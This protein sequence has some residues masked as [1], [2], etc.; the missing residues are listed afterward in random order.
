MTPERWQMV[1]GILESAMELRPADRA[2]Y[3]DQQCSADPSL[4]QEVDKLLSFEGE[5]DPGFLESPVAPDV[6][7]A[8]LS[9]SVDGKL[10]LGT[11]LGH[12]EVQVLLGEGGMGEVYRGRDTRLNRTVA[13]KVIPR[14]LS[15]DPLRRQRFD[16]EARAISALQ[17]P[18]ICTLYDVGD[19]DETHFLVME[20]LEGETLATRLRRGNLPLEL[21][22]RYAAEV[23]DA[24][25]AAHRRGIVH[26][27]LKPANIFLTV[28]GES[29]VLD[30]GLAKLDETD[31]EIAASLE[32][33]VDL[34]MLST[35]GLAMGTVPYMSPEQAQGE[36]LDARA[37]IFSL[38]AVLYE[39][40]TGQMAFPGKTAAVPQHAIPDEAPS[41]PSLVPP[42]PEGL[43]QVV[44]KA[45]EKHRDQ[46][47]QSA[48][49]LRADLER[50]KRENESG[51][52]SAVGSGMPTTDQAAAA[53][54]RRSRKWAAVSIVLIMTLIISA[55]I[56]QL[57]R[58]WHRDMRLTDKDTV[59]LSDFDNLTGDPVFDDT[60]KTA[61]S[62]SLRQSPFLSVLTDSE[63]A[64]A[65]KQMAR[66]AAA[67]VTPDLA[68]EL[69]LRIQSK[70]YIAGSIS[71]ADNGFA[72]ELKAV[73][74]QNGDILV[75][76]HS[77]AT[78][79]ERVLDSL[80]DLATSLRGELGESLST[81]Q[82]FDAPPEQATTSSL[83]ALKAYSLG[84][85]AS[86]ENGTDALTYYHRAIQLDPNFAMA[87]RALGSV[88]ASLGERKRAAEYQIK[89]FQLRERASERERLSIEAAYYSHVTGELEKAA[90]VFQQEIDLYPRE[91]KALGE[92]SGT[93]FALG[94]FDSAIEVGKR[95]LHLD[96]D[97]AINY[98]RLADMYAI[99]QRFDDARRML[100]EAH[101]R[102]QDNLGLRI[103]IYGL[104][105]LSSD[106]A[107]MAEQEKWFA[108][109]GRYSDTGLGLASDTEAFAGRLRKAE[110]LTRQTV[111]SAVHADDREGAGIWQAIAAQREAVF[112]NPA[113]A[114]AA[115]AKALKLA[116]ESPNVEIEAAL[117]L[118]WAGGTSNSETIANDLER[119]F[120]L[121]TQITR[122]W[123][124]AIHAQ[125]ALAKRRPDLA[126]RQIG[127][128]FPIELGEIQFLDS[129]SCLYNL[130][131]RADTLLASG[132][133]GEAA[134]EFQR[135]IDHNGIVWNCWTGALAH[136][137]LARASALQSKQSQGADADAARVRALT[138]YSEFL[139]LWKDAD[140]DITI[141]KQA[142]AEYA[143]LQ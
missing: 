92:L 96:P 51:H 55:M 138:A 46:R 21:T 30:F 135:L 29:K 58:Y 3:L 107:A 31:P 33:A 22:L 23:A 121:D 14:A 45:L 142:K 5:L 79:K 66:P 102:G 17:H 136:L 28:R 18:N 78:S 75:R 134:A 105:F 34:R 20:Y 24:L 40:A 80:V 76:K 16:R 117:A 60:L 128:P 2:A 19:Q 12:Y 124:P 15:A 26:R 82:K 11:R 1:R 114:R 49:D 100:E 67:R 65:L 9:A 59:V 97:L 43:D 39:M 54:R 62:L 64:N 129:G 130:Y 4:R 57:Y 137:G 37:D 98:V 91:A 38:G 101:S 53:L 95:A 110:E 25:D 52:S 140:P 94:Q 36:H 68:R 70:A 32:T 88:Y 125:L 106:S 85:R 86:L 6:T 122:I 116:P 42:L 27:D 139:T 90:Q 103:D 119:R 109:S 112:G 13:I 63:I 50:L 8:A 7:L 81:I 99:T 123:L 69:C 87:Y 113:G 120:P 126:L 89:A 10:A 56:I 44:G 74:C 108:A 83:E 73:N 47:Y 72:V 35:P 48:A 141:L 132:K 93:L 71:R 61:L 115:A 77:P 84:E 104:A 118:A 127:A 143:K 111:A 131:I 41:S 133:G